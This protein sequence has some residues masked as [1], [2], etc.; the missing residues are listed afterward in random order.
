MRKPIGFAEAINECLHQKMEAD[1]AVMLIGQGVTSPWYVGRTTVGLADRF[2]R[3]RVID[4]PVSE[5]AM[6]GVAVGAA[7]AGLKPILL[8]PRMDFMYYALDQIANH[9]AN[10]HYMFGGQKQ[11]PL[12]IWGI[13]NRGGEQAAQHAQSLQALFAH[14][15]GLKVV[16]P[17]TPRDAKGLL[18]AAIDD[19][20]PVVYLDDRWLYNETGPVPE[21]MVKTPLGRARVRRR[22]ADVTVIA[23][24][25]LTSQALKAAEGLAGKGIDAEVIDLRTAKPLD[26]AAL[27]KSVRKTGRAVVVDGGWRTC[28]LA[29][30]IS[31]RLAESAFGSLRSPVVRVTLPDAPAPASSAQEKAYYPGAPEIAAA[32]KRAL[33]AR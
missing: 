7:L 8:F 13:V 21:G 3:Q 17:S 5:N 4:T 10:W 28:G 31:A 15:P 11:V 22:G 23:S 14:I 30:D 6:S 24:S 32:V 2:G 27:L 29:A 1:P 33:A 18:L 25:W 26:E 9:A 16:M 12:T 20:N 19:G